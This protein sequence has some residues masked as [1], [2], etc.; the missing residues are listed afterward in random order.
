[1]GFVWLLDVVLFVKKGLCEYILERWVGFHFSL[2]SIYEGGEGMSVR[3]FFL[4]NEFIV[5]YRFWVCLIYFFR[6]FYYLGV[7]WKF[8][9]IFGKMEICE[10]EGY[11]LLF[12]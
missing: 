1:M 11:F 5:F 2:F 3:E 7:E 8:E 10:Y 9:R 12:R 6:V 4:I